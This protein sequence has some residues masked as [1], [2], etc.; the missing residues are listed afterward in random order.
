MKKY[1]NLRFWTGFIMG[2]LFTI[3]MFYSMAYWFETHPLG[4]CDACIESTTP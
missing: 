4:D 1:L 3:A 2:T